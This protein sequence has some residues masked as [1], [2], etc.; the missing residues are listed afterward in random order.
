MRHLT[1]FLPLCRGLLQPHYIALREDMLAQTLSH[2][3]HCL[4]QEGRIVLCSEVAHQVGH[5]VSACDQLEGSRLD[6]LVLGLGSA[7]ETADAEPLVA[8]LKG[9][10]APF[11]EAGAFEGVVEAYV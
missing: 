1:Q 2:R 3:L 11:L 6:G 7:Q 9:Y 10:G 8:D 5:P 4:D